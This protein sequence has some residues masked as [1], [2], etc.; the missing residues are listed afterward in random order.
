MNFEKGIKIY[1]IINS[2]FI[3]G[4]EKNYVNIIIIAWINYS[5]SY[6]LLPRLLLNVYYY[7]LGPDS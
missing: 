5:V 7:L 2:K 4:G 6:Q 1:P 3:T